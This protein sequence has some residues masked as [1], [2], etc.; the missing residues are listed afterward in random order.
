ME[1]I[2]W[3]LAV[4]REILFFLRSCLTVNH[5]RISDVIN[6][7]LATTLQFGF[8]FRFSIR[9][10]LGRHAASKQED[11]DAGFGGVDRGEG[12]FEN[13]KLRSLVDRGK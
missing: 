7:I 1:N 10:G 13:V 5:W 6:N 12:Q 2:T 8:H 3:A 9:P 4:T 11:R